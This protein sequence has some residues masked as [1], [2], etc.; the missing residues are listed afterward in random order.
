MWRAC[1]GCGGMP[2]TA[3]APPPF[4]GGSDNNGRGGGGP[5]IGLLR[6]PDHY[7]EINVIGNGKILSF[8]MCKILLKIPDNFMIS[9]FDDERTLS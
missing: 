7:E 4:R 3:V 5:G 6:D 1:E 9:M 2:D 8:P